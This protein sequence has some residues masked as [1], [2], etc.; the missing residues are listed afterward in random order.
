MHIT[1]SNIAL[2]PPIVV[3][4]AGY[5][6]WLGR[7]GSKNRRCYRSNSCRRGRHD[8]CHN[9]WL[10]S[11][12]YSTAHRRRTCQCGDNWRRSVG[13]RKDTSWRAPTLRLPWKDGCNLRAVRFR[14]F[15]YDSLVMTLSEQMRRDG[16]RRRWDEE[17]L[18]ICIRVKRSGRVVRGA[19]VVMEPMWFCLTVLLL[20]RW[21]PSLWLMTRHIPNILHSSADG[22]CVSTGR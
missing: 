3:V 9:H 2:R 17:V 21:R 15:G 18:R 7:G 13:G 14:I 6:L 16:W 22:L 4:S 5:V 11:L 12:T 1:P 20:W 10:L 8:L 19:V